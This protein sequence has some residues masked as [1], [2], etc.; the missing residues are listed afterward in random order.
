[1]DQPTKTA[2]EAMIDLDAAIHR[3][4]CKIRAFRERLLAD[5]AAA[6]A[7][8]EAAAAEQEAAE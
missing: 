6:R 3:L 4:R 7:A 1:M 8:A 2:R 5:Q